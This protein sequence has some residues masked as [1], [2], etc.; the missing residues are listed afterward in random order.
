MRGEEI[1]KVW[2]GDLEVRV[3]VFV[4]VS[5]LWEDDGV[6]DEGRMICKKKK[7]VGVERARPPF[8]HAGFSICP[9]CRAA[10]VSS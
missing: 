9:P 6:D 4:V 1:G 10:S 7:G 2:Y 5:E 3:C 8:A